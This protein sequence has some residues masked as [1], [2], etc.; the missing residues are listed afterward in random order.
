MVLG[1]PGEN[2][3]GA[4]LLY[5]NMIAE[6]TIQFEKRTSMAEKWINSDGIIEH[7]NN[8]INGRDT[9]LID[10]FV[11]GYN[12]LDNSHRL[13]LYYCYCFYFCDHFLTVTN[14]DCVTRVYVY[15]WP[16]RQGII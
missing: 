9:Y 11:E 15:M 16:A 4:Q 3:R 14:D 1:E 7:K 5:N 8:W 12:G 10:R 6:Y 2:S 13:I